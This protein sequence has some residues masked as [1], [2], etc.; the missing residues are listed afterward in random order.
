ML[1]DYEGDER[2]VIRSEGEK[3][4]SLNDFPVE[5]VGPFGACKRRFGKFLC[6]FTYIKMLVSFGSTVLEYVKRR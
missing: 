2:R 3:G 1:P 6:I 4:Y 5:A